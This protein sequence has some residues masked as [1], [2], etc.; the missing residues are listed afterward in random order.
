[1]NFW[2]HLRSGGGKRVLA[3]VITVVALVLVF[4]RI[5]LAALARE[6]RA[7]R[8]D[9]V[10]AA[11]ATYGLG[12]S[13]AAWR[14]HLML[15]LSNAAVTP[16]ATWCGFMQ[17][18][19]FNLLF[20]GPAGGDVAKTAVYS[21]WHR[22]QFLQ[23]L[24]SCPLDRLLG[25]AGLL[26]IGALALGFAFVKG[27]F[28]RL[29]ELSAGSAVLRLVGGV[30]VL[31]IALG[32][33]LL[34]ARFKAEADSPVARL[35]RTFT[36][37]LQK[38]LTQPRVAARALVVAIASQLSLCAAFGFCLIA[39]HAAFDWIEMFWTL[40]TIN[41]LAAIPSIAGLGIRE[42]AALTVLK[43]YDITASHAVAAALLMF[44]MAVFWAIVGAVVLWI[45]ERR[46]RRSQFE[47]GKAD[48]ILR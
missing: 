13:L 17:G 43:G 6:L 8:L 44:S 47:G 24:P 35:L 19:F 31:L 39:V 10:L 41:F 21:R 15:G 16:A 3:V 27:S 1:M 46:F 33:L 25:L 4:R 20:F 12:C 5:D 34:L 40:P 37:A 45:G 2:P 18:H 14:W 22:L 11:I 29:N 7:A 32:G 28:A 23:V 9:A 42:G 26:A 30:I 36:D 48:G 38:L